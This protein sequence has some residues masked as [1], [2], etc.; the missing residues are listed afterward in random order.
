MGITSGYIIIAV[1]LIRACLRKAPKKYSYLL[2]AVVGFRLICPVSFSSIFSIFNFGLLQPNQAAVNTRTIRYIPDNIGYMAKPK[3]STGLPAADDLLNQSL[4]AAEP[5]ASVNPMQIILAVAAI[6]WIAGMAGLLIYSIISYIRLR[7]RISKAVLLKDNIYEC[8]EI[9]SPFVTGLIRP[10]IYI[11]F[12]LS[13]NELNYILKHEQHH[14]ERQDHIVKLFSYLL[15]TIYWFHPLVWIAF[16]CMSKDMEMSCDEKVLNDMGM[17]S[18]NDYSMSL[19]SFAVNRRFPAAGPLAFGET[20][21]K[22]RIK[23]IL[24]FKKPKQWLTL[25]I[26]LICLFTVFACAA[27]PSGSSAKKAADADTKNAI[28]E[29]TKELF[30]H[31]NLFIGDNAADGELLAALGIGDN[32]GTFTIELETK[33]KPYI[34]RLMFDKEVTDQITLDSKM[35]DYATLLLAL[36]DNA[37]EIQWSY[38]YATDGTMGR[39]IVNWNQDNL[40]AMEIEDVKSYGESEAKL[41]ELVDLLKEDS[42]FDFSYVSNS[43]DMTNSSSEDD[44][45]QDTGIVLT[46]EDSLSVK[47]WSSLNYDYFKAFDNAVL[48]KYDME[49]ALNNYIIFELSYEGKEYE[50]QVSYLKEDYSIDSITLVRLSDNSRLLLYSA[51]PAYR[52]DTDIVG[53]FNTFISMDQYLTYELPNSFVNSMYNAALGP[54]GGNLIQEDGKQ[55]E[56]PGFAPIEWYAPGG[57]L[58]LPENN[59]AYLNY[60]TFENGKLVSGT[61]QNNHSAYIG[62]PIILGNLTEQAVL[63]EA[64]HDLYTAAELAKAE[65][66]GNPVPEEERTSRMWEIYFAREDGSRAFCIFLNEKDFSMDDAISLAESV[67]FTDTAFQ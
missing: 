53:F 19:L 4:P 47:D 31:K 43:S 11:P 52:T 12:R 61:L 67:K 48:N 42:S 58:I 17:S 66:A 23:N 34:L 49:G 28:T 35:A 27:N 65:E 55:P 64:E 50:L 24:N 36:I 16:L 3:I 18:K 8:D 10:R 56:P 54:L 45:Q 14:M 26:T 7:K 44:V 41:Q 5:T 37:D 63:M 32:L 30:Q 33:Q 22:A 38:P 46:M 57:V 62:E 51:N 13:E 40:K 6:L 39:M 21:T 1:L 15:L 2:W 59:P 60:V 25:L 29:E 20:S 9:S